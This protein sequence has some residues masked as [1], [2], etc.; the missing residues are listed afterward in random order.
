MAKPPSP[1]AR[2]F[3]KLLEQAIQAGNQLRMELDAARVG[4][5]AALEERDK[6][7]AKIVDIIRTSNNAVHADN[8]LQ[9]LRSR[10]DASESEVSYLRSTL[11][12]LTNGGVFVSGLTRV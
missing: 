7:Q 4:R 2:K 1:L 6:L 11:N 8:E 12:R 10:L 3:K 5:D 9:S